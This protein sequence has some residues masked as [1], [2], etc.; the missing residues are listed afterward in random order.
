ME[1]HVKCRYCRNE[2]VV[3]STH[4]CG[5]M[6]ESGVSAARLVDA[7]DVDFFISL[8]LAIATDDW[9]LGASLASAAIESSVVE[10]GGRWCR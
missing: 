5:Q 10:D 4:L 3:G 1:T 7:D 6:S 8:A 2:I 9:F